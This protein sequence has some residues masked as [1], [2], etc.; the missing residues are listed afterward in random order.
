MVELLV[1]VACVVERVGVLVHV[2]I[3]AH[4]RRVARVGT[5]VHH[6]VL[7]GIH[8]LIVD[9]KVVVAAH[10]LRNQVGVLHEHHLRIDRHSLVG[11]RVLH[12]G[13]A[14]AALEGDGGHESIVLAHSHA[15]LHQVVQLAYLV[16]P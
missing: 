6:P 9:R 14:V 3:V 15:R 5:Q 13:H 7:V 10:L 2:A 11:L 12:A 1:A 4:V 16:V 8:G